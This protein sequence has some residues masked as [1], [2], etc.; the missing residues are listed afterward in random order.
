M[1]GW[2]LRLLLCLP[3][4]ATSGCD[5]PGSLLRVGTNVWPG[6]EPLYLAREQGL[7]SHHIK[8]VELPSA[9][10]VID[11]LRLGHLEGGAL[12]LDE[13]LALVQEGQ[14]LVVVLVFN[15]SA[16]ADMLMV[17]PDIHTLSDLRG[18]TIALETTAVGA[19][20]LKSAMDFAELPDDSL[21]I[22]HMNL[23]DQLRA[24]QSGSIDAM[25]TYEPY[26]SQ[27]AQ[28]GARVL[29]DS[30]AIKGQIVDVLAIRREVMEQQTQHIQEL[31]DGYLQARQLIQTSPQ[32]SFAIMNQRL[33]LPDEQISAMFDGLE[34]PDTEEN[35]RLLS[36]EPSPLS[37]NADGLAQL[38]VKQKL[39]PAP[40]QLKQF[41]DPRFLP[42]S[43]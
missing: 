18:K 40:P 8:L 3:L 6:Y 17:H 16:G 34:L 33:R 23:N 9:S 2:I 38:M 32:T 10:D 13:V 35:R 30:S 36:G 5:S 21:R 42:V 14:D 29:F 41:T 19:L 37:R 7:Y 1:R 26:S 11:A 12:T 31:I 15:I 28:A 27:L 25:I 20:M 22:R 4:V 39:M 43:P 24:Y